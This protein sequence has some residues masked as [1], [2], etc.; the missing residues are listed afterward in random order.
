[1]GA[2]AGPS[3]C[4]TVH[5]L[6]PWHATSPP[7]A[8]A[9]GLYTVP[10]PLR[11]NAR[12][13]ALTGPRTRP[14][15]ITDTRIAASFALGKPPRCAK[16]RTHSPLNHAAGRWIL[17]GTLN[18]AASPAP[19]FLCTCGGHVC[20]AASTFTT[21]TFAFFCACSGDPPHS[22]GGVVVQLLE[23][24]GC[25]LEPG[26]TVGASSDGVGVH[27]GCVSS[28]SG[29]VGGGAGGGGGARRGRLS[30]G[31]VGVEWALV[32]SSAGSMGELSS[33]AA[34]RAASSAR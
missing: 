4:H 19:S 29:G 25:V 28:S 2:V 18:T 12:I 5:L 11:T 1:M 20:V 33:V 3:L 21:L 26:E 31:L 6:L 27:G 24:G 14:N 10:E 15:S 23:L 32:G 22:E 7:R 17:P 13:C 34:S 9:C 16:V 8:T 30:G